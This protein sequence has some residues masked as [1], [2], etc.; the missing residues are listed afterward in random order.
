MRTTYNSDIAAALSFLDSTDREMWIRIGMAVKSALGDDGWA[1]WL[2]WSQT[3]PNYNERAALSAWRSFSEGKITIATLFLEAKAAGWRP[4][5]N[6]ATKPARGSFRPMITSTPLPP[7]TQK[8]KTHEQ[9]VRT[10]REMLGRS[11]HRLHPYLASKGLHSVAMRVL[12]DTLLVPMWPVKY[13]VNCPYVSNSWAT[14]TQLISEHGDK[15]FLE[16]GRVSKCA[17]PLGGRPRKETITFLVEGV[18]TGLSIRLA[19]F[20]LGISFNTVLVCFSAN[21]LTKVAL[22]P[23]LEDYNVLVIGD[24]DTSGVGLKAAKES[25]RP[26]WIPPE[27][28]DANDYHQRHGLTSLDREIRIFLQGYKP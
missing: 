2:G 18:A 25:G 27:K 1:L 11:R 21:N 23:A 8:K 26:Y 19:L 5:K 28:G 20:N 6:L 24:N 12:V 17:C 13:L 10:A 4:G 9:A 15:L 14:N 7:L 16:G 3:A 22:D